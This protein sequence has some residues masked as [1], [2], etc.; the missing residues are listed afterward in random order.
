LTFCKNT[1]FNLYV[2][3]NLLFSIYLFVFFL[4][5]FIMNCERTLCKEKI[6]IFLLTDLSIKLIFILSF[7]NIN[8]IIIYK[9]SFKIYIKINIKINKFRKLWECHYYVP[10]LLTN[11]VAY[12]AQVRPSKRE[13]QKHPSHL[14]SKPKQQRNCPN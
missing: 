6:M 5:F 12:T 14:T 1:Y 9:Y 4:L 7:H 10:S 13:K 3:S 8:N 2:I 11:Y